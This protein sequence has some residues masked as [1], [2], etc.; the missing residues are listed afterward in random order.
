VIPFKTG[1]VSKSIYSSAGEL[2]YFDSSGKK[3]TQEL[4]VGEPLI[5]NPR[6]P[7]SLNYYGVEVKL[8]I[9]S[10]VKNKVHAERSI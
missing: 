5:F 7:H 1:A 6:K 9:F 8:I 3:K 10:V 2:T 4:H